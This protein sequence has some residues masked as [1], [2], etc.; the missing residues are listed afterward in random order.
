M[1]KKSTLEKPF[2]RKKNNY[3]GNSGLLHILKNRPTHA[4]A[5]NPEKDTPKAVT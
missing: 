1:G 5:L 3:R 4:Y 2:W